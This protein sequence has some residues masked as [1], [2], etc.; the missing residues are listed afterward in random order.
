MAIGAL[1]MILGLIFLTLS[2]C[3][4]S[5]NL[6]NICDLDIGCDIFSKKVGNQ[7]TDEEWDAREEKSRQ[8]ESDNKTADAMIMARKSIYNNLNHELLLT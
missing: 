6:K 5:G 3:C 8:R 7:L 1:Q 4:Y 2:C